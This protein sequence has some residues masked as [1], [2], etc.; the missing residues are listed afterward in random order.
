MRSSSQVLEEQAR[1][2][3]VHAFVPTDKLVRE[4][5]PGHEA[6][7]LDPKYRRERARKEYSFHGSEGHKSLTKRRRL[8]GYPP[9]R[10]RRL[11]L[12][13]G[14]RLDGAKEMCALLWVRN[15]G[16]DQER[17]CL[18]VDVF[19]HDLET[20]EAAR[21]CHLYLCREALDKV[22]VDDAIGSG[23]EGQDPRNE[24]ALVFIQTFVPV[25]DVMSQVD[26]FHTPERRLGLLIHPPDLFTLFVK[27]VGHVGTGSTDI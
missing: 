21:L 16:V 9:Q 25:A 4:R 6:A 20:V 3:G 13:A 11:L 15:V 24:E 1:K 5:Q 14:H 22:L 23:E 2:V 27:L 17:V 12:D 26:F 8:V 7:F 18:R 10:P 19:H